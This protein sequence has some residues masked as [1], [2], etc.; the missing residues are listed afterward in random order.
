MRR[1]LR[2]AERGH[3]TRLGSSPET[4]RSL[5]GGSHACDRNAPAGGAENHP[6]PASAPTPIVSTLVAAAQRR[7]RVQRRYGIAPGDAT[8]RWR[9]PARWWPVRTSLADR[10]ARRR[11]VGAGGKDPPRRRPEHDGWPRRGRG[12]ATERG[13]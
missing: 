10:P 8:T 9:C 12:A 6:T 11:A 13:Q 5:P 3:T 4:P 2:T 7:L 1:T